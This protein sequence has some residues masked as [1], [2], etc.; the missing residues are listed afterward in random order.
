MVAQL[1]C[2]DRGLLQSKTDEEAVAKLPQKF[3]DAW[4]KHDGHALA[5][6]MAENVDF[7]TVATIYLHGRADF[8]TFRV[9]LLM[10]V[11]LKRIPSFAFIT[12]D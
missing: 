5:N 3:C 10:A 7:V 6:I 4:T 12:P 1:W 11:C 9:R 2:A 8:E